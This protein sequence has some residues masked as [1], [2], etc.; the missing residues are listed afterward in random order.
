MFCG[1]GFSIDWC[2]QPERGLLRPDR[3]FYLTVSAEVASQRG[4][5]GTERY[6]QKDFQATVATMFDRLKDKT[7]VVSVCE[8][9]LVC[10]SLVTLFWSS[11]TNRKTNLEDVH[12]LVGDSKQHWL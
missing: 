10:A 6:E 12:L 3:V 11:S 1:Q 8:F 9:D 4:D 7:W 2:R 5:Y